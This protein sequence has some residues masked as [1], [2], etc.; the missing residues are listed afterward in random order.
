LSI[1]T[2]WTAGTHCSTPDGNFHFSVEKFNKLTFKIG[3]YTIKAPFSGAMESYAANFKGD[4]R[5]PRDVLIFATY[6]VRQMNTVS[7][8]VLVYL[9]LFTFAKEIIQGLFYLMD[10]CLTM[11]ANGW[12]GEDE[13]V[14][15]ILFNTWQELVAKGNKILKGI[16]TG[17][18]TTRK[19]SSLPPRTSKTMIGGQPLFDDGSNK[20]SYTGNSNTTQYSYLSKRASRSRSL[21]NIHD[22]SRSRTDLRDQ[23][24]SSKRGTEQK[25]ENEDNTEQKGETNSDVD[26]GEK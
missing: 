18:T 13:H 17:K 26:S 14:E 3:G 11:V 23:L 6:I 25:G 1:P 21:T 20:S 2:I 4:T 10:T 5:V 19:D 7:T 22:R 24:Y 9:A 8:E 12:N 15:S 16:P